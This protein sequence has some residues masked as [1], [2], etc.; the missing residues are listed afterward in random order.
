[1]R[2]GGNLNIAD[3]GSDVY[4]DLTLPP[5]R[6]LNISV[7]D[8]VTNLPVPYA[9][10]RGEGN[11]RLCESGTSPRWSDTRYRLFPDALESR[12]QKGC[13]FWIIAL[14]LPEAF[15]FSQYQLRQLLNHVYLTFLGA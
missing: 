10:V 2:V 9:K 13:H 7:K 14:Q 12:I 8:A 1:M 11:G 3:S 4:R 6:T 5:I 15:W